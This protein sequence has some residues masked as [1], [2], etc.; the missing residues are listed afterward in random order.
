MLRVPLTVLEICLGLLGRG[1]Y[2]RVYASQV[3]QGLPAKASFDVVSIRV[4]TKPKSQM[5]VGS[6]ANGFKAMGISLH[7]LISI[8]YGVR[9]DRVVGWQKWVDDQTFDLDA[10]CIESCPDGLNDLSAQQRRTLLVPILQERFGVA[11]HQEL[12]STNIYRLVL[13][14]GGLKAM[15]SA[16]GSASTLSMRSGELEATRLRSDTL[17][18]E[19]GAIVGS[20]VE[21]DTGLNSA[22]DIKL[23][24]APS[25]PLG[26]HAPQDGES[27]PSIF[28]ALKEEL[29]MQLNSGKGSVAFLVVDAAHV[30]TDN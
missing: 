29:G 25:D 16:P 2:T 6:S 24:W 10:K 19:L 27:R 3:A 28:S 15:P 30:P 26:M 1:C 5:Q 7:E 8:G 20:E 22:Y 9:I 23:S 21:D 13:A 4:S 12:R 11:V 18:Q 14:K 17:A